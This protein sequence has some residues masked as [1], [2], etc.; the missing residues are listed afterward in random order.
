MAAKVPTLVLGGREDC[1]ADVEGNEETAKF[2]GAPLEIIDNM[3][4]DLMLVGGETRWRVLAH[5]L[6]RA[7]MA[8]A[9]AMHTLVGCFGPI[10]LW[11][12]LLN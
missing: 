8:Y 10:L 2:Y 12:I 5:T 6:E 7:Y 3:S 9:L 4:H 1:I 11:P